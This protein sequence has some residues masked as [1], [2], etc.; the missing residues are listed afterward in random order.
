MA[1]FK[2]NFSKHSDIYV[3]YRPQYPDELY[4]YL[5]SLTKEHTRVWDCGTGN[6]QAAV[7]LT[8][9]YDQVI[10]TDPSEQQIGNCIPHE[11]ITYRVEKG[12]E[13]SIESG[14]VDLVTLANAIH[15]LD[16]HVFNAQVKRVLKPDGIIAAWAYRLPAISPEVDAIVKKFHDETVNDYWLPEN[17][18]VEEGYTTIPFPFEPIESPV[19]FSR[20]IMDLPDFIGFLNTWSALQRFISIHHFNPTEQVEKDLA[21]V[22][23]NPDEQKEVVW[24]LVLKTGK[25]TGI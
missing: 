4:A 10:A 3:K 16:F 9:F 24:Q 1:N 18:L 25:V 5:A 17:R 22:W 6:G 11:K 15:W 23:G 2:D 12:E 19:F 21:K 20:K 7:G 14:T 13:S 8:Q